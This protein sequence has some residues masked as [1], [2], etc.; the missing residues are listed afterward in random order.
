[1]V[2]SNYGKFIHV[3]IYL[4]IQ[5]IESLKKEVLNQDEYIQELEARLNEET[6]PSTV[7]VVNGNPQTKEAGVSRFF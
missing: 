7:P 2:W 4:F 5:E 1:M 6:P 3:T